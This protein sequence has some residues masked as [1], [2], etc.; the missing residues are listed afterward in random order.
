MNVTATLS[1]YRQAPRKVRLVANLVKGRSVEES[2]LLLR[3]RAKRASP[4]MEKLLRSAVASAKSQGLSEKSLFVANIVVGKG[5]IMKRSMPRAH[6]RAFPIHK[7]TS[8]VTVTITDTPTGKRAGRSVKKSE[9]T[10]E[11]KPKVEKNSD[12][13]KV[14]RSTKKA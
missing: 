2:L 12:T 6:G 5:P 8:H 13:A 1:Q 7:H 11:V 3:H 14:K 4:V 10:A 9:K